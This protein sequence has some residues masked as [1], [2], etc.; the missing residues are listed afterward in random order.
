M[1]DSI[2]N[3]LTDLLVDGGNWADAMK[4]IIDDV[5][6]EFIRK[7]ISQPLV[8]AG[9]DFMNDFFKNM[10][11]QPAGVTGTRAMGGPVGANKS[12]LVG[13]SGPEIFT[14]STNGHITANGGESQPVNITYNI[15]SWD[16]RDTMT[17]LQQNAP[18]IV[19]IIQEAFQKR[20]QRGFA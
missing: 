12:F 9:G 18:Q 8:S 13:E 16:S 19:G 14:P 3:T 2:S 17:T 1:S 10:F 6:R 11:A 4:S 20:G 7:Q 15:K 5:Y